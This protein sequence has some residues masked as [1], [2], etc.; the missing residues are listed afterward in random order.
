MQEIAAVVD[1]WNCVFNSAISGILTPT[2]PK[3]PSHPEPCLTKTPRRCLYTNWC[4]LIAKAVIS[5]MFNP[6]FVQ[7]PLLLPEIN[8]IWHGIGLWQKYRED[9]EIEELH[10]LNRWWIQKTSLGKLKHTS[11][12]SFAVSVPV[13]SRIGQ[14]SWR[15]KHGNAW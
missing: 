9:S 1:L 13:D 10:K 15:K 3:C 8:F 12:G 14:N 2:D 7:S 11:D 4:T 5:S 6:W